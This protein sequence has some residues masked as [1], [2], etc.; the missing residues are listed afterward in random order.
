MDR[1]SFLVA[2]AAPLVAAAQAGR[3]RNLLFIA[4]DDLNSCLGCYGHPVVKTPNIDRIAKNGVRFDRAYCQ[5]P[6]CSPSR[7]SLMTGL[8]PDTTR[9]YELRTHFR[10]VLPEVMTLGQAFQKNGYFS[11]RV[12]KGSGANFETA[13][14][15]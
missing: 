1:R 3:K 5:F 11:G 4:T 13:G 9:V 6:L 10:S 2:T 15:R 8:A 14:E 7:T 12:G